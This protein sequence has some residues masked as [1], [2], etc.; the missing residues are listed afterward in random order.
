MNIEEIISKRYNDLK[1]LC[2]MNILREIDPRKT[3]KVYEDEDLLNSLLI[4]YLVKY[5]DVEFED[6]DEG[7]KKIKNLFTMEKD[8]Y[9]YKI[10]SKQYYQIIEYHDKFM[11]DDDERIINDIDKKKGC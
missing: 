11:N 4:R 5:K 1:K 7:F 8:L 3:L 9:H 10:T 2:R 6:E